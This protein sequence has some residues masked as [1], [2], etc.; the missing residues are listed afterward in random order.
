MDEV[1]DSSDDVLAIWSLGW[2]LGVTNL[3]LNDP[4]G[5]RISN[6][7]KT[8][9]QGR[10]KNVREIKRDLSSYHPATFDSAVDSIKGVSIHGF[11]CTGLEQFFIAVILLRI[12]KIEKI[13]CR[14]K[15]VKWDRDKDLL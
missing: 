1:P 3:D 15:I 12:V 5:C 14:I 4:E 9:L 11:C 6:F 2:S 8:L 7:K 10:N 13:S